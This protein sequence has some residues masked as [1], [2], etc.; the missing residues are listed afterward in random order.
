MDKFTYIQQIE[1]HTDMT[2]SK[3]VLKSGKE[4]SLKR[5]HPWVFSGAIKKAYGDI[6]EGD[7]VE[8][9]SNQ[10]EFLG[11]GHY[12]VGSIAV[13]ILS[14]E[15]EDINEEFWNNKITNAYNFRKS[16]HITDNPDNN[17]YRLVHGEGDNLPGLIVD[18]YNGTIVVQMHSI[19]MF[20]AKKNILKSLLN[21][22]K[23]ELFAVYNKSEGTLPF[24]SDIKCE[25]SYLYKSDKKKID[26]T[27]TENGLKFNIDWVTGQKTGFFIDQRENRKLVE[28][29]SK[30]RKVAN[31]FGY[32]GGFS[33]Y[34]MRG[35]AEI[36][37]TIDSSAKAIEL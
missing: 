17:V 21:I 33:V 4:Q 27:I 12:Q 22:Y 31:I 2:N 15:N 34:A 30:G 14:F 3:I 37:H 24:K 23:D 16:F 9:Y 5:F 28:N 35:E 11:K 25:N 19:G 36:V 1:Q 13:R 6:Y 8:V 29:Y 32:T 10:D 7:I 20:L 26:N 18:F